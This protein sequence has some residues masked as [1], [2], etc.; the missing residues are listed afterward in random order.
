MAQGL[1]VNCQSKCVTSVF[2]ICSY[3]KEQ[4]DAKADKQ[5]LA[6]VEAVLEAKDAKHAAAV[7]A[8]NQQL[9]G[10]QA[11]LEATQQQLNSTQVGLCQHGGRKRH[12]QLRDAEDTAHARSS[13]L[14]YSSWAAWCKEGAAGRTWSTAP[15]AGNLMCCAMFRALR[16][17]C[18][19]RRC[20][21]RS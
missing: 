2:T 1:L 3:E 8:L 21:R 5:R 11:K 12:S 20:S 4:E 16:F 10:R 7:A 18:P 13:V 17:A 9:A 6:E 19:R 14:A 15:P